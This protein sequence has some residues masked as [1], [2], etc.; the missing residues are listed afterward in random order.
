MT[1]GL[2]STFDQDISD[3]DVR[4]VTDMSF[5]F[6]QRSF[7]GTS[8][9][10]IFNNGGSANINN[11]NVSSVTT[12]RGMFGSA[13]DG[14]RIVFNQP[15]GSWDTENV[16]DMALM[17]SGASRFNR[18]IGNWNVSRVT[19]MSNMFDLPPGLNASGHFN[20]NIGNWDVSN[21]TD[22]EAMFANL[23][24]FNNAGSASIN[25]WDVS[26]VTNMRAMFSAARSFNQ[27]IGS[28]DVARVTDMRAMFLAQTAGP[29]GPMLFNQDITGWDVSS[30]TTMDN[31]FGGAGELLLN[32][33]KLFN[34]PIGSWDVSNVASMRFM[35]GRQS[36][37]QALR[38]EQAFDQDLSGWSLRPG[39]VDMT[40]FM[41]LVS[42]PWSQ[43]NYSRTLTGWANKAADNSG[44]LSANPTFFGSVYNTTA[45]RPGARFA[46]A[47]PARAFLTSPRS[48]S[49][50]DATAPEADGPYP[51]DAAAGVYLNADGWYFLKTGPD[52]TLYD[53]ADSP[54]A[55]GTGTHPWSV[56][57]WTGLLSAATLLIAGVAWT[58]IGDTPA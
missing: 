22:M 13:R 9:S 25:T 47:P 23:Y 51:F 38:L 55:S 41:A 56:T 31:M 53:P 4:S 40:G 37:N 3:W 26:S 57:N 11:W 14:S 27:P 10:V 8:G 52:W 35:F 58:L 28:W 1:N 15:I 46:S 5:M 2:A 44:P 48:L 39:G 20:Q 12:M 36:V 17:F 16:T 30:V 7:A 49:V 45:Y 24:E 21:V 43:E 19:D 29:L 32:S 50:A 6:G 34:Q 33:P 54:Q 42:T 18:P